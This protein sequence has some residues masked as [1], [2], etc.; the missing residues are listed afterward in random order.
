MAAGMHK[1][2]CTFHPENLLAVLRANVANSKSIETQLRTRTTL[3]Q[4]QRE[5]ALEFMFGPAVALS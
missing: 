4:Q 1:E 5:A 3:S 2:R